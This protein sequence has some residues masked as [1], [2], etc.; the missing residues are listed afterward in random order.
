M[1][2]ETAAPWVEAGRIRLDGS[3]LTVELEAPVPG[4]LH[5]RRR[6]DGTIVKAVDGALDLAALGDGV[7][8]LRVGQKPV[9]RRRDGIPD[10]RH[11][12]VLPSFGRAYPAFTPNNS[13]AVRVGTEPPRRETDDHVPGAPSLRRRL[14]GPVAIAVHRA[15]IGL[16]A[17]WARRRRAPAD[18][19]EAVHILL[20]NAYAMGGTVRT[21]LNLAEGLAARHRVQVHSIL[22]RRDQPFFETTAE[23]HPIDDVR[24]GRRGR[25]P[26]LLIHPDDFA[27]PACSLRTDLQLLRALRRMRGTLIT[28]RPAFNL[29]AARL[30]GP[31]LKVVGAEHLHFD[32]HRRG[33]SRDIRRHYGGLDALT[34]LTADDARDYAGIAPVIER[35]PNAVPPLGG[36]GA[37]L[38]AP[39]IVAA[40]RLTTQKGFDRL[41]DAFAVVAREHPQWQLRIYGEGRERPVLERQIVRR[42][43]HDNVFLMGQTKQLPDALGQASL[44]VLSSRFEGF[45]IVLIEAMSKGLPVVSFDCPRGPS[46][47]VSHGTDGLLVPDGDVAGLST[48]LLELVT[49]PEKRRRYGVAAL[50]KAESF[51]QGPVTERWEALLARL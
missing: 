26:S 1:D 45:G 37:Q 47:I 18:A 25:L 46:E 40:G 28:T 36:G 41:I 2:V 44:F 49:D 20:I 33:L 21:V 23:L 9:A 3:L 27:Y 24:G 42:G 12:V 11:S 39:V 13:L 19:P 15:A 51:A 32:A 38:D 6:G 22:R 7:W 50:Q 10:K 31:D 17:P 5:A 43:L 14:L 29:L 8:D 35:I 4:R 34:V 16:I 30:A 48:A